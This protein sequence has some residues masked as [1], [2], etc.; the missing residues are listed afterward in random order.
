[1][2]GRVAGLSRSMRCALLLRDTRAAPFSPRLVPRCVYCDRG[3]IPKAQIG[4]SRYALA[5]ATMD[6]INPRGGT[7]PLNLVT[8][9]WSCNCK[10]RDRTSAEWGAEYARR[11]RAAVALPLDIAAGRLW[12]CTLYPRSS[13]P[14]SKSVDSQSI[15]VYAHKAWCRRCSSWH[16]QPTCDEGRGAGHGGAEPLECGA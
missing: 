1:V 16:A 3:V 10:K 14:L 9:C 12:A 7:H 5:A 8:A 11:A 2:P 4:E 13:S 6:H 15:T